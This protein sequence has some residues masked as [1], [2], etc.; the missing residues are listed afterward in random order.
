MPVDGLAHVPVTIDVTGQSQEQTDLQVKSI[1]KQLLKEWANVQDSDIM[2]SKDTVVIIAANL[3]SRLSIHHTS[4]LLTRRRPT[5]PHPHSYPAS[6]A[7]SAM[8]STKLPHHHPSTPSAFEF[9]AQELKYL[10]IE[11]QNSSLCSSYILKA[12]AL[13]SMALSPMGD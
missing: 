12:S 5:H 1:C 7:A 4:L 13:L 6:A 3:T 8:L 10:S 2:V 9:M 11:T